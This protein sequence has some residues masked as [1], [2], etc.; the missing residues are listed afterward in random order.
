[1]DISYILTQPDDMIREQCKLLDNSDLN[2]LV[3]SSKRLYQLCGTILSDRK[4]EYERKKREFRKRLWGA[5]G[6]DGAFIILRT[7]TTKGDVRIRRL[8]IDRYN[9][10]EHGSKF[11]KY[12]LQNGDQISG[13]YFIRYHTYL[14]E[15][16]KTKIADILFDNG[17]EM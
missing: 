17:Y 1:M 10:I 8:G 3:L 2:R 14:T 15:D 7:A 9:I 6:N 13:R 5:V 16:Q 4:A 12:I 11:F